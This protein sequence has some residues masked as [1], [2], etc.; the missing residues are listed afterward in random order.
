MAQGRGVGRLLY[1]ALLS[2]LEAQGFTQAIAAISLPN[3]ASV[4]L[5]E[6]VGFAPAGTYRDVGFKLGGWRSVGLWQRRLAPL[7]PDPAEPKPFPSVWPG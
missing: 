3:P 5:H 7:A 6:K 1:E 4:R 2:L